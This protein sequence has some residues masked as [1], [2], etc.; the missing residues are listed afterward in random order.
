MTRSDWQILAA[1]AAPYVTVLALYA[2]FTV[3][4]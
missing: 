1:M 4:G 3:F 2:L